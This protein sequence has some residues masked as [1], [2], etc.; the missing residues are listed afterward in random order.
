MHARYNTIRA[1]KQGNSAVASTIVML[2]VDSESER[3]VTSQRTEHCRSTV[4]ERR[5]KEVT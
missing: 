4:V 3:K 5:S 1:A 2:V